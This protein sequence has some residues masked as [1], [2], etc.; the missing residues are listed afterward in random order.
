MQYLSDFVAE[1]GY[2]HSEIGQSAGALPCASACTKLGRGN[3]Q[4]TTTRVGCQ[5]SC[6]EVSIL[7]T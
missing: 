6:D 7:I 4:R 1:F 3:Q 5:C 2:R